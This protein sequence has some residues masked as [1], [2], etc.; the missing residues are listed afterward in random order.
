MNRFLCLL[1]AVLY[2]CLQSQANAKSQLKRSI[3]EKAVTKAKATVDSAYVYSRRESLER[4]KRSAASPSEVLRL[5]KQPFGQTRTAVRAADYMDNAIRLV[6][7]SLEKRQKRSSNNTVSLADEDLHIIAQLTGC[8]SHHRL[9]ACSTSGKV[10]KFY[11]A[12]NACNNKK[13]PQWGVSNTALARWLHPEYQNGLSLP[14]GWDYYYR[15]NNHRLPLVREVSNT[16]LQTSNSNVD[17]DTLYTGLL[18]TFSQWID[19]DLSLTPT[20]PVIRSFS[21]GKDCDKSCDRI[22]PCFPIKIPSQDPHHGTNSKKCMPFIRSA[23]A[24]GSHHSYYS[25]RQQMNAV[26]SFLDGGQVYGSDANR[27]RFLRDFDSKKGL[28]RINKQYKDGNRPL[29]PF[30]TMTPNMCATRVR[31]TGDSTAK[32]V[33]CFE[34]GDARSNENIGL[35]ALHTLYLREHNRV[36][37]ALA[38]I[39]PH[40][41][42]DRLYHEARK[43]MAAY[44]QVLTFR[45]FLPLIVGPDSTAKWLSTYPGYDEKVDPSIS[46]VFATAAYRFGHLM[47]QP[48]I[49]RLNEQYQ[50]STEHPS[51]LL[52]KSLFTPWR[53]VFEGGIDLFVRGLIG[54]QA[55]LNTQSHMMSDELREKLFQ[56]T[57]KLGLDLASLNM[58]RGRDHGLP[59]YNKWRKFCGLSQ[60]RN[61]P[62]LTE[63][64]KNATL[65][66]K[67]LDLYGTPEN[68]D[69]WFGGAAEPFVSG[70]RVGP[71]FACLIATQFKK[72]RQGDRLWWENNGVFTEAQK[73]SLR[74]TSLAR[75]ICDN[76]GITDVP[77]NP[78]LYRPRGSG[79]T[80]CNSISVFDLSP[81]KEEAP[82][83]TG[84][85]GPLGPQGPQGPPG[86]SGPPGPPGL[87]GAPGLRGPP[88]HPGPPGPPGIM[89]KIAFSVRLGYNAPRPWLPISFHEVIYNGQNCYNTNTGYFTCN[90]PGVYEFQFHCSIKKKA[91]S[92]CLMRNNLRILHSVTTKHKGYIIVSGQTYIKLARGD[93][94]YLVSKRGN[95]GLTKDCVFSGHLLFTE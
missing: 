72:T 89:V 73:N 68:I 48:F 28:L 57:S 66:K 23:P 22:D 5:L 58:Q 84:P 92:L 94:V 40:W 11:T 80:Q 2:L 4:V 20:S 46:N 82:S 18:V 79:Y 15:F 64:L 49:F 59:G 43:I 24:C 12:D 71:L 91:T 75:I 33:P 8:A 21:L 85:P 47:L 41:N 14:R 17:S 13:H 39:N 87:P 76:T 81:W 74:K 61:L 27:A 83:S 70:G 69:V 37:L 95:R 45:D 65:A 3:I 63:V 93:Q 51:P 32:E 50:E 34:A 6:K 25:V 90:H 42:G 10:D 19:H 31:I 9:Y 7:R 1:A 44:F 54:R 56:F 78:F 67:L 62:E 36:A 86:P 16:L 30:S 55:K 26:T 29:M 52:H 88:G 53:I 77:E 38:N 60:P 35:S